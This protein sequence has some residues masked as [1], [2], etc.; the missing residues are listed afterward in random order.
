MTYTFKDIAVFFDTGETGLRVLDIAASLAGNQQAHLIA[1]TTA[2]ADEGPPADH[3]A[4]GAAISEVIARRSASAAA[5]ISRAGQLL[6]KLAARHGTDNTELRVIA[7]TE[8]AGESLLHVLYCDLLVVGHPEP[9]GAPHAWSLDQVLHRA[10]VPVLILPDAWA[11]EKLGQRITVAWNA[12]RPARRALADAMPLLCRAQEVQLLIV[13]AD[14]QGDVHGEEPGADIAAYLARHGVQVEL[15]CLVSRGR[16]VVEVIEEQARH[17]R[18][19]LVVFG[20]YSRSRISETVFGG[21]TRHMLSHAPLP[22]FVS[23]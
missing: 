3:F 9:H 21:V 6:A 4:R 7:S 18:A 11:G 20:A 19:D 2:T 23:H 22:L 12:S 10:G 1:M 5:H 14:R 8:S 16:P 13:D 15:Q 17:N